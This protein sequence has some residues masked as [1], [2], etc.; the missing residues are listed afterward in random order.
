MSA[1]RVSVIIPTFNRA[2][3]LQ[4]A[5]NSALEQSFIS[6]EVIVV[7]DGS[8]DSTRDLLV[9]YNGRIKTIYQ[10]NGGPSKA[11]NVGFRASKG[12]LIA[13]LD[14][15]DVWNHSKISTQVKLMDSSG[16][17][18][19][20]CVTNAL[21]IGALGESKISFAVSGVASDLAE[22]YW[23]NPAHII[24]TRF[25]LFNQVAL[26]RRTAFEKVGGFREDMRVLEDYDLAFR[27]ALLGP[28]GFLSKAM[29][30]K[31]DMNTGIGVKAM[32]SPSEHLYAWLSALKGMLKEAE[33]GDST[34]HRLVLRAFKEAQSEITATNEILCRNIIMRL[35]AKLW[36]RMNR[37]R[38]SIRRRLP[39]WPSV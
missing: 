31:Y 20:C 22:G 30:T 4:R 6:I 13:F 33:K 27:L 5:I 35:R 28:W 18:V 23:I 1:P 36:I 29:V 12:E 15:D 3:T 24:A 21:L 37:I 32:N 39:D 8:T 26:I 11:R 19:P 25:V 14:S 16:S 17:D 9:E 10:A 38:Q 2:G 34:T 7:D